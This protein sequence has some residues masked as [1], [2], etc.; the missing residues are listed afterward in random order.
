MTDE[1]IAKYVGDKPVVSYEQIL[2]KSLVW[3]VMTDILVDYPRPMM[4]NEINIGGLTIEPDKSLPDELES[5]M[6][7][8]E[9]GTILFS[10]GT[11]AAIMPT[12]N[13]NK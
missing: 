5:F 6:N 2:S 12:L 13:A 10:F 11:I 4:P 1:Y 3:L 7:A 8:N 9:N